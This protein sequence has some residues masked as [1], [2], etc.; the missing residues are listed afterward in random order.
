[1]RRGKLLWVILAVVHLTLLVLPLHAQDQQKIPPQ[2]AL[3]Y[4]GQ[5]KTVCGKVAG[6]QYALK[7]EGQPTLLHLERPY[8]GHVFTIVIWGSDRGKFEKPPEALYANQ[9]V[10]VT[11]LIVEH[12]GKP[13]IVVRNPSQMSIR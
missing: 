4:H 8:P 12:K 9:E 1:M 7:I 5:S 11:G 10:C 6:V 13:Q 3:K 2:E